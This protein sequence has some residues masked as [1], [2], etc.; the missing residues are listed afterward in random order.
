VILDIHMPELNGV[1]AMDRSDNWL[2]RSGP[3]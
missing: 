3:P 2:L 1:A